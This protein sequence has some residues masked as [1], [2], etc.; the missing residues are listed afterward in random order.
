MILVSL[1][2]DAELHEYDLG[3]FKRAGFVLGDQGD[4]VAGKDNYLEVIAEGARNPWRARPLQEKMTLN[5]QPFNNWANLKVGDVIV[6]KLD[7][8]TIKFTPVGEQ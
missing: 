8:V 5:G 1:I 7:R 4:L 6:S 3:L 2:V